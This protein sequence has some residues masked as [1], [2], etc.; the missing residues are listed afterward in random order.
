MKFLKMI[1]QKSNLIDFYDIKTPIGFMSPYRVSTFHS[2]DDPEQEAMPNISRFPKEYRQF[3]TDDWGYKFNNFGYRSDDFD[4]TETREFLFAGCSFTLGEGT[5]IEYTWSYRFLRLYEEKNNL[6]PNSLKLSNLGYSGASPEGNYLH[7][8]GL[9]HSYKHKNVICLFPTFDRVL[10]THMVKKQIELIDTKIDWMDWI[11]EKKTKN[12]LELFFKGNNSEHLTRIM[13]N[14]L[15][16]LKLF[17]ESKG[18][19]FYWGTWDLDFDKEMTSLKES[20]DNDNPLVRSFLP[21]IT[22]KSWFDF[23]YRAR[24]GVHPPKEYYE[25]VAQSF[26]KHF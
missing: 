20:E 18:S 23:Q 17:V 22:K 9:L 12:N 15:Y 11:T 13:F 16:S 19:N 5:P 10:Y 14:N 3:N 24:D 6:V 1:Y 8:R 25:I 7:I 2:Y 26:V 4:L 21:M